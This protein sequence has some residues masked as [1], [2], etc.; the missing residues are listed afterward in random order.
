VRKQLGVQ[1][2]GR[3]KNRRWKNVIKVGVLAVGYEVC[4]TGSRS[5]QV[6]V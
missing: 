3:M 2:L 6:L 1:P 4:G 5:C